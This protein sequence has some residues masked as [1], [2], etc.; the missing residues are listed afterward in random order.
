MD[1]DVRMTA[2]WIGVPLLLS[3]PVAAGTIVCMDKIPRRTGH[4]KLDEI[5]ARMLPI[6][7][8]SR[9]Q[10][11]WDSLSRDDLLFLVQSYHAQNERSVSA[12]ERADLFGLLQRE[13]LIGARA[14]ADYVFSEYI[15]P[16]TEKVA[17]RGTEVAD[18]FYGREEGEI[19]WQASMRSVSGLLA[20]DVGD[21]IWWACDTCQIHLGIKA[22]RSP[23]SPRAKSC[24]GGAS[25]SFR[26]AVWG[27]GKPSPMEAGK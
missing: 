27:D 7:S 17:Y 23:E 2:R 25:C 22:G 16:T 8:L 13:A 9:G 10:T 3:P 21:T 20:F 18:S 19:F 6:A 11:P 12:L 26:L 4:D 5:R 14:A 1:S 15:G 24:E